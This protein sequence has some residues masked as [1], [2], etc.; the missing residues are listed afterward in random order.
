VDEAGL[1]MD[2][3]LEKSETV[4]EGYVIRTEPTE[5]T[6]VESEST[7][8]VYVSG[9]E[10][11]ETE[12]VPVPLLIGLPIEDAKDELKSVGLNVGTIREVES[13]RA[14]GTVVYQSVKENTEVEKESAINLQISS[15]ISEQQQQSPSGNEQNPADDPKPPVQQEEPSVQPPAQD[16]KSRTITIKLPQSPE[17]FTLSAKINGVVVYSSSHNASEGSATI[18]VHGNGTQSVSIYIDN[19]LY[20]EVSVKFD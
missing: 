11:G 20:N 17:Q 9:T 1:K 4:P 10:E 16:A 5:G 18:T 12:K 8:L 15:G 13:S 3:V 14:K 19:K 2:V 7:V 6:Q